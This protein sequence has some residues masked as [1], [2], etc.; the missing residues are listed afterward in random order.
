MNLSLS[1]LTLEMHVVFFAAFLLVAAIFGL[2]IGRK[3][4]GK[5]QKRILELENEMLNAHNEILKFAKTNK[6]LTE[7][8]E[9]AKIPFPVTRIDAEEDEDEKVRKIPLGKIG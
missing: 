3:Q 7:T 5:K 4:I 8:L 1:Q 6:Q 2:L 9:K